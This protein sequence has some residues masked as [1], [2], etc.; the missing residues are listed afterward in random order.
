MSSEAE[1]TSE[2]VDGND[3]NASIDNSASRV[4]DSFI[5]A[6]EVTRSEHLAENSLDDAF[7]RYRLWA[8]SQGA[9]HHV[10]D[11]RSL[12]HKLRYTP[13]ITQAI[14]ELLDELDDLLS[15]RE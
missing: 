1:P 6:L 4:L 15:N 12:G 3:R 13:T 10:S 11:T 9:F 8:G 2:A 7:Q 5:E 14:I